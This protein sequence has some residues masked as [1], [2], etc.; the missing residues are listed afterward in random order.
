M[1]RVFKGSYVSL[2]PVKLDDAAFIVNLRNKENNTLFINKTSSS[3][4]K[5]IEWMKDESNDKTSYYF[6]ILDKKM[7]NQKFSF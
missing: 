6:L 3:V 2:H 5:Q 4:A 7:N 1:Y